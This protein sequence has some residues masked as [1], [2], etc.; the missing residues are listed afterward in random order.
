M[1]S[2]E[3]AAS[4]AD[5]ATVAALR[6]ELS[7]AQQIIE[8]QRRAIASMQAERAAIDEQREV[9]AIQAK[10]AHAAFDR[11]AIPIEIPH[12][13]HEGCVTQLGHRARVA[14]SIVEATAALV[15]TIRGD[16]NGRCWCRAHEAD[17][18]RH[19]LEKAGLI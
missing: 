17:V 6:A 16:G 7:A 14:C 2:E 11:A 4:A 15:E 13:P 1:T 5:L 10:D 12:E 9:W 8:G 18:L 3:I 19:E